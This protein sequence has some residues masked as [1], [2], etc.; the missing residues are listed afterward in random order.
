MVAFR[1]QS[2]ITFPSVEQRIRRLER[3][4][5]NNRLNDD[6]II[7]NAHTFIS[8]LVGIESHRIYPN[9]CLNRHQL[10]QSTRNMLERIRVHREN[11]TNSN[12]TIENC[13]RCR[14]IRRIVRIIIRCIEQSILEDDEQCRIIFQSAYNLLNM[15]YN[16][17]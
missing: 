13:S 16:P 12:H 10:F 11:Q 3:I 14:G 1:N 9:T 17:N 2:R 15:S 6:S 4:R 7:V 5:N 8:G